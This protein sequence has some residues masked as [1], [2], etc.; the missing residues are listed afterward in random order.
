RFTDAKVHCSIV[1]EKHAGSSRIDAEGAVMTPAHETGP[2]SMQDRLNDVGNP[3]HLFRNRPFFRAP[4]P[5]PAEYTGWADEQRAW[6]DS[7]TIFDQSNIMTDV[8][9]RGPDVKR[10][11]SD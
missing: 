10:L 2:G 9:F 5:F 7:V 3:S 6:R 11:F 8:Y 4:F 1:L